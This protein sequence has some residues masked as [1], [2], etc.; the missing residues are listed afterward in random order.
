MVRFKM[1]LTR[2][3][4]CVKF[5]QSV[6]P[7]KLQNIVHSAAGDIP[8]TFPNL[9]GAWFR[10]RKIVWRIY[11]HSMRRCGN[12]VAVQGSVR[13]R[14]DHGGDEAPSIAEKGPEII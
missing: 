3:A 12:P 8:P 1:I 13:R 14:H 10:D 7:Y 9:R 4:R 11:G 6:M 5:Q 2:M